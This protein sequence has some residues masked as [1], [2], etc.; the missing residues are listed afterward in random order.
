[1]EPR[2]VPSLFVLLLPSLLLSLF[3][4]V[5][6]GFEL[7]LLH[8]NDVHARVEETSEV[9]GACSRSKG[10]HCFG[11]VAR[12]ATAVKRLRVA[13]PNVLLL[14]AG[15]QFQGSVWFSFYKGAEAAHFMNKLSY[16]AM[17]F[18]NHEFD[19]GVSGLMK[20]F[21]EQVRC[22]VL[23]A[24]IRVDPPLDSTFGTAFRP[25]V[26]LRVGEEQV[27]VVGYTSRET[28][29]L[30]DQVLLSDSGPLLHFEDELSALQRQ[31]IALGHS[32]FTLDQEV[33]RR[34]RGVDVVIGGHSNTFLYT[35][36]FLF[37]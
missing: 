28:P 5:S 3:A 9:S 7:S 6:S 4:L 35:A 25:Y 34:V 23:S 22:P 1:M 21:L 20:P 17:A 30:S 15:D 29:A 12:R 16:D 8:T 13:E 36:W 27:G 10:K 2:L 32:G 24:N 14:D 18:G 19:N 26:V 31:I 33:A 37:L 11:G